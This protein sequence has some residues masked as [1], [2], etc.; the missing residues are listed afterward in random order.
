MITGCDRLLRTYTGRDDIGMTLST[1]FALNRHLL[2]SFFVWTCVLSLSGFP[3]AIFV[4][5]TSLSFDS[6]M[7]QS[8]PF[9]LSKQAPTE[10]YGP[11]HKTLSD[12]GLRRRRSTGASGAT[13]ASSAG[14]SSGGGPSTTRRE[15]RLKDRDDRERGDRIR[16]STSTGLGGASVC[17]FLIS[18][19][20]DLADGYSFIYF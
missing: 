16:T 7:P 5:R 18:Y 20:V 3:V 15:L 2:H 8:Y 17:Y 13:S 6:P 1:F 19:S 14:Y 10:M 11:G 9:L 12:F 4:S